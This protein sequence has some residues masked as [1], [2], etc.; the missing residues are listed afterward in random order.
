MQICW[1]PQYACET[2]DKTVRNFIWHGEKDRAM[3][4]VGWNKITK[5]RKLGGLGV[6]PAR[7]QN[8]ALLGKLV[9]S[10]VQS[11][12]KLWVSILAEKYLKEG[13]IFLE[14]AKTGS[15]IWNAILKTLDVLE[16]GFAYKIGD[17]DT[18]MWFHPWIAKHP[19]INVVQNI[20]PDQLCL[21]IKDLWVDG[22]SIIAE[23]N[24]P[25]SPEIVTS[26]QELKPTIISTIAD[27][28]VWKDNLNGEYTAKSAYDWL[29]SRK[30]DIVSL[31]KWNWIWK[32]PLSAS[33]QFFIWQV[34]HNSIPSKHVLHHRGVNVSATCPC[35]NVEDESIP[36]CLILCSRAVAVWFGCGFPDVSSLCANNPSSNMRDIIQMLLS[37]I[38]SISPIIMW[39]LWCTRNKLVFDDIQP[40]VST[41][42]S[43]VYAQLQVLQRAFNN[44]I[45]TALVRPTHEVCW[46]HGDNDTMVLNVDC[47]ALTNPGKA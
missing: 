44:T 28:W 42:V 12:K 14:K 47:S 1:Y 32:L 26:V 41:T 38:G 19:L 45:S 36:H 11:D 35:C 6:R 46:Q 27:T 16:D 20:S 37:K 18:N 4:I 21:K 2:L 5:P 39:N 17:G 25:L 8:T 24:L 23:L 7:L 13:N 22:K 3:H 30:D 43:A 9:W 31:E 10:L 34:C 29:L 33:V 15:P 40:I